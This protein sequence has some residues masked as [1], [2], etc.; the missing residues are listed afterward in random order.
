MEQRSIILY[1]ARKRLSRLAIHDDLVTTLGPDALS[2][3]SVMHDPRDAVFVSSNPP[4]PLH[5]AEAE[6]DDCD[7]AILIALADQ[8]FAS[9][10]QLSQLTHLPRTIVHRRLT[11]SL[12]FRVRN[13]RCVRH[14]LAHSQKLDRITL[15]QQFF[16][17]LEREEQRSWH[18]IVTL[19]D[20]WF[21]IDVGHELM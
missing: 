12:G 13:L 21:Y 6:F 3:S 5:R 11:N 7:Q 17:M 4:T 10:R 20:S 19:D 8:S 18:N 15:S 1:L 14:L 16:S 2:Y 9:V